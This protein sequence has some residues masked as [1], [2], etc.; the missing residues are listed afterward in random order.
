MTPRWTDE[1]D[2][3][4]VG[5]GAGGATAARVLSEAGLEVLM[6]EEGPDLRGVER[7]E[8]LL[9]ALALTMR[10]FGSQTTAGP[11]PMPLLQGRLVGGS[12]AINS[13]IVWRLPEDVRRDW[14]DR[15]GLG[16]LLEARALERA[17]E[18]IEREL[19]VTE[20][21]LALYGGNNGKM[22][23]AAARLGLPGKPIARN[24]RRC[25][26]RARCLQGCPSRAR[27]SMDVSYVPR[28]IEMGARL[29]A[30]A[31][32][33]RIVV[34]GGRATGVRGTLDDG[35]RRVPFEA[36]ARRAVVVAAGA[37]HTPIL[38][39]RSGLRR[40]VGDRFQAHPGSAVV[41]RFDEPVVMAFGATQGYEV[42]LRERGF[43]LETLAL[44][45]EMLAARLPGAGAE[46]QRRLVELDRYAQWCAQ[47]RFR[48]L[49][50]VRPGWS[51]RP[52]VRYVPT[53]DDLAR[54]QAA[55]ALLCE[56]MFAAGAT[57]VFP[58]LGGLPEVLDRP[59]QVRLVREA[60]LSRRDFHLIASH[61]FGTACAHADRAHGVVDARLRAHDVERLYVMDASVFPT[62]LGVN[63]QHSIMAVVWL[64][65]ERLAADAGAMRAAA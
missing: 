64:A 36:R 13:G 57:E 21:P 5:T 7:P 37:L 29:R 28:A 25:E 22:A 49:G 59:E 51:G 24:A 43:K 35:D 45:P 56:M 31:R 42:P 62:N 20:T 12:T 10:D 14:V 23:E 41:G 39:R 65:A 44:P 38:L 4:V 58:G 32:V 61:L 47:V 1:A 30:R 2:V 40:G 46:W 16:E 8:Q 19:E 18:R 27:Q 50:T 6:L 53:D 60:R 52:V 3:V 54:M 63:P 15:F 48:A 26:G 11:V 33:E 55:I 17:F 9:E 34:R